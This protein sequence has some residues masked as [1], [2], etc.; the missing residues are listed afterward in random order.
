MSARKI[1]NQI[2]AIADST[3]AAKRRIADLQSELDALR[4]CP[5]SRAAT[6]TR[7]QEELDD[8]KR[9]LTSALERALL[10]LGTAQTAAGSVRAAVKRL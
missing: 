1:N 2:Q 8:L 9:R 7:K 5:M 10:N 3:E 6:I 4:Q